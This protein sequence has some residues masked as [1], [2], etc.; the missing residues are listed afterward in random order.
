MDGSCELGGKRLPPNSTEPQ[1]AGLPPASPF[2]LPS[3]ALQELFQQGEHRKS[4]Q[5]APLLAHFCGPGLVGGAPSQL[6]AP[7]PPTPRVSPKFCLMHQPSN[8]PSLRKVGRWA[9]MRLEYPG[10]PSQT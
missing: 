10:H 9:K 7:S 5:R 2:L 8:G 6:S 1:A 3:S 4:T